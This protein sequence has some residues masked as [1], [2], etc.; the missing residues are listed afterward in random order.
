MADALVR[1]AGEYARDQGLEDAA[2]VGALVSAL[3]WVAA[4]VARTNSLDRA[5]YEHL[6]ASHCSPSEH[7]GP[8]RGLS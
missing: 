1:V 3:G 2:V 7:C 5:K 8:R 6:I 4:A